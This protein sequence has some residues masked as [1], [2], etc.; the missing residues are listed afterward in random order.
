VTVIAMAANR[1]DI[2]G[3]ELMLLRLATALGDL[4][5]D[6]T[7]VAPAHPGDLAAE[8]HHRGLPVEQVACRDRRSYAVA[9]RR[10][11]RG[12]QA[13]L[14]CN[15][16]LPALATAGRPHRVVHLHQLPLGIQRPLARAARAGVRA[17]VVPSEYLRAALASSWGP[18]DV[19]AN[20][21]DEL[22]PV[23]RRRT[24]DEVAVGFLGRIGAEK[25]I[26]V[27][28]QACRLLDDRL[29]SRVRL[30]VAGDDRFVPAADRRVAQV[31]LAS[32]G[33]RVEQPGWVEPTDFFADVDLA[34]FPSVRP[35]SFGLVVA[36]AM[37]AGRPVVVSDAGAL[38]EVV[39]PDHPWV[40]PADDAPAL[41][42]T[43]AAAVE[44]LPATAL[45]QAQR[46]RWQQEFS[47][48]AGRR[49]VADLVDRLAA[50]GVLEAGR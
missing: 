18:A 13:L 11:D 41:A 48:D 10:W 23:D 24:G 45:T 8:A 31:A 25:G 43:I 42:M 19:L 46:R 21:T 15:G 35:E 29:R 44:D 20:W 5:H 6:V 37:A 9:L 7:V 16:L 36:E 22:L 40:V 50:R 1:G 34:V 27:L 38:P 2:G 4:G 32:S 28:A 33:V 49:H 14:W 12:R 30:V 17:T 26:H 3:G 39:G 47:P